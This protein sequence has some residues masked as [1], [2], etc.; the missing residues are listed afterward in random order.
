MGQKISLATALQ[1]VEEEKEIQ[2]SIGFQEKK[3]QNPYWGL[4]CNRG[5]WLTRFPLESLPIDPEFTM[6]YV[7][8]GGSFDWMD[9]W[10]IHP[11]HLRG[12]ESQ[13]WSHH[14]VSL[15]AQGVPE[16]LC[17]FEGVT[18][19]NY[20]TLERGLKRADAL[21]KI[22]VEYSCSVWTLGSMPIEKFLKR[23]F[24]NGIRVTRY[25]GNSLEINYLL[26]YRPYYKGHHT[27]HG[28][29]NT[30][31]EA[32]SEGSEGRRLYN[33]DTILPEKLLKYCR[34]C[35]REKGQ[36][37]FQATPF[38]FSS[39]RAAKIFYKHSIYYG[40]EYL[41]IPRKY[42][43]TRGVSTS[44]GKI[45]QIHKQLLLVVNYK[46]SHWSENNQW[47]EGKEISRSNHSVRQVAEY[48]VCKIKET[49]FVWNGDFYTTHMESSGSLKSAIEMAEKR[50]KKESLILTLNDVRNDRSGTA[51]FCLAG[52]KWFLQDKMPFVYRMVAQYNSWAEIP[53]DIMEIEF[54]LVSKD[55][56]KGYPSPVH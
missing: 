12:L 48:S 10:G 22:G 53:E 32:V 55:I 15:F 5:L 44:Y 30:A 2:L 9:H 27:V 23:L 7:N 56:F 39:L 19:K 45:F 29:V 43:F 41:H 38:I 36:P 31:L 34:K 28:G 35:C 26:V 6:A 52:T 46:N 51:G 14:E 17:R 3:A 20:K 4:R 50:K 18:P 24:K 42:E 47:V 25:Y 49:W 8:A 11:A 37:V 40:G 21:K 13:G 16:S 54:H 33:T 1:M